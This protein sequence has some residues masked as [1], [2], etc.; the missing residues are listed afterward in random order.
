MNDK[1]TT[2]STSFGQK[3]VNSRHA[4]RNDEHCMEIVGERN[5]IT[6]VNHSIATTVDSTWNALRDLNGSVV[7]II[8]GI[9]RGNDYTPLVDLVKEKVGVVVCLGSTRERFFDAFER[10]TGMMVHAN[11]LKEAVQCAAWVAVSGDTVLFAPACPSYHAFD[12]Y[13][14]RGNEFRRWVE[15]QIK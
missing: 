7:L 10:H 13:K 4:K 12:N 9:D 5:G 15:E 6:W 3:L 8:G 2:Q 1:P 14:N 11:D